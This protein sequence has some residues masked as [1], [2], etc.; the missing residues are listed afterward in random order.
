MVDT[1][2]AATTI[3]FL[4]KGVGLSGKTLCTI[5]FSGIKEKQPYTEPVA[6]CFGNQ[7][8]YAPLLFAPNCPI[9]LLA[10]DLLSRLGARIICSPEGRQIRWP[11]H[12]PRDNV[13]GQFVFLPT[14]G[15]TNVEIYWGRLL[16]DSAC[17][18]LI[19]QFR[20]WRSYIDH[21]E[22]YRDPLDPY[23][24]TYNFTCHD[25]LEYGER[26]E[27]FREGIRDE[28]KTTSIM[29]GPEGI[30]AV[31]EL[32]AE[33]R[34][35]FK[36]G[37]ESRPHVTLGVAHNHHSKNLGPMI[38]RACEATFE[39]LG[40]EGLI[41]VSSDGMF[42]RFEIEAWDVTMNEKVEKERK[43]E[44]DNQDHA[45]AERM[46][47][48][49][50]H[51][52]WTTH[53]HDVGMIKGMATI[54]LKTDTEKPVWRPQY[55]LKE[56]Q[57]EGI[58]ETIEGLLRVGVLRK[59][60]ESRWNTPIMPVPKG[61]NKGWRMVHD[62][63]AINAVTCT[64]GLRVPDPYVALRA[65]N[66]DQKFFS[67]IDLAN[68]FFC[69]PLD[70]LCQDWF[71]FTYQ[72]TR[73]TYNRLPQG[74]KDSPGLFNVALNQILT[75]LK[76]PEGVTIIQYVDDLL[77][78][79]PTAL[80]ALGA[81]KQ[82][83]TL[84]A[85]SGFK[86]KKEKCQIARTAV[87]FLGRIVG[88]D[89]TT[90]SEAHRSTI[91]DFRQPRTVQDM[92]GFLGLCGYSRTYVPDY[93]LLTQ[94]LR[95]MVTEVGH[96]ALK[97]D[98]KWDPGRDRAFTKVKQALGKAAQ[99][100]NPNYDLEFVLDV[101]EN[102]GIVSA[103][104]YQK[105]C[106]L[107][108]VL[109]YYSCTLDTVERGKPRCSRFLAAVAKSIEKTA[110]LVLC[111]PLIINT[112]H[113]VSALI[114]SDA[115]SFSATRQIKIENILKSDHIVFRPPRDKY[116]NMA[117]GVNG[118]TM[119]PH[120][121]I[122]RIRK[123]NTLREGLTASPLTDPDWEMF[124][125]GSCHK[126]DT[127][128]NIAG[129]AV[130]LWDDQGGSVAEK[131][132]IPQPASAQSAEVAG[133]IRALEL[134]KGKRV[135]IYTDSAYAWGAV[136]LE[137]PSWK[138]R[139]FRTSAGTPVKHNTLLRRLLEAVN[140]PREVGIIKVAGHKKGDTKEE[141]GNAFAD[142]E[143]KNATGYTPQVPCLRSGKI[144]D[145]T[146]LPPGAIE[147]PDPDTGGSPQS[148]ITSH[149][150]AVQHLIEIQEAAS[151]LEQQEWTKKGAV[152]ESMTMNGETNHMWRSS[153][154]LVVAPR[155][156]L[157]II[158]TEIHGPTHISTA[159]V[160]K[161]V[162]RHWW[163][164]HLKEHLENYRAECIVCNEFNPHKTIPHPLLKFPIPTGPWAE[165]CIDYT[166]MGANWRTSEGYRFLL[167]AVDRFSK[168]VEAIPTKKEDAETVVRWLTTDLIPRYGVPQKICTDNGTHFKNEHL[169]KVESALGIKHR[170]GSV[171]HPESQG[172]VERANRTI[173]NK[174]GKVMQSTTLKWTEA[175]PLVLLSMRQEENEETYLSPHEILTGRPMPG[176]RVEPG[177]IKKG[178]DNTVGLSEYMRILGN[179]IVLVTQ[180]IEGTRT[181]EPEDEQPL[182]KI[183]DQVY[184]KAVGRPGWAEK[185]WTGPFKVL[186]VSDRS[187]KI[188]KPGDDN[189]HHFSH[190]SRAKK[191]K[192]K[193]SPV[194]HTEPATE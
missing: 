103:V 115:F 6:I 33:Q 73:Y 137:G 72:G 175:L 20:E 155:S 153:G 23:H 162:K 54:V 140:L 130:V 117:V 104:L 191:G 63:R 32:T 185:K 92:L 16:H 149:T 163:N 126:Q 51:D 12:D 109:C 164:P 135:N 93:V 75:T 113:S 55:P 156:L 88:R 82:L 84:L 69:L 184:L 174:L 24:V 105:E 106:G 52:I 76:L 114:S 74:Y 11:K 89:G 152:R 139:D 64:V 31:V 28:I 58:R 121:C 81:T 145:E 148:P 90:M 9:N 180:Q 87:S 161:E 188:D 101:A 176:P 100:A 46:L 5:G 18:G 141:R 26:W 120:N 57:E 125:D 50:P 124:T 97:D 151:P 62:L 123:D 13:M 183:G 60:P 134:S 47:A 194:T 167:V 107:R 168:W 59:A 173:K 179:V 190:C 178:V 15:G 30:A 10:R 39:P 78:A 192:E 96:R 3:R 112:D 127:G 95:E 29:V 110:H 22:N 158:F 67:V 21:Y 42:K 182:I 83:L 4:P 122:E 157:P 2:A 129:Y 91:L 48:E 154:G 66:P 172:L 85:Q 70:P 1:G 166:D 71:A 56:A 181:T 68:A 98:I 77:V 49:I 86:V 19:R 111:H 14:E 187:V 136:H 160:L 165:I 99:L 41:F 45:L 94:P 38:K 177:W 142:Q 44:G 170:F 128:Q 108:K 37:E 132:T 35:W 102:G 27:Q 169:Q 150:P 133:L 17:P 146:L 79:A 138:R 25:D 65:L 144:T 8:I 7:K 119:T 40:R 53:P 80:S 186:Q 131:D 171:Y 189:W 143:A 61:G 159:R 147:T 34:D 116:A 193:G 118:G 36:L 43:I